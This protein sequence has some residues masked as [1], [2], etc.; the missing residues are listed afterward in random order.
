MQVIG[1]I[2]RDYSEHKILE[3]PLQYTEVKNLKGIK[4]KAGS[5]I[6]KKEKYITV[7]YKPNWMHNIT[8]SF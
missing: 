3:I 7:S 6:Y 8:G 2:I 1:S 5:V 4:G